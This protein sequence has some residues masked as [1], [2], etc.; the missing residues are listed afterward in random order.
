MADLPKSQKDQISLVAK[1]HPRT[2]ESDLKELNAYVDNLNTPI[3]L[4]TQTKLDAKEFILASDLTL[5]PNSTLAFVTVYMSRPC[6]SIQPGLKTKDHIAILTENNFIPVGYTK[7]DSKKLVKR[8]VLNENYREK[9]LIEQA[10]S[11]RT[12]GK[13]SKY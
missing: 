4:I 2:P 12:D 10:S 7:E 6:I 8:A 13:A 5:T 11:F 9:K 3:K 1:L